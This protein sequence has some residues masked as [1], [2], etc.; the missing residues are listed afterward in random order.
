[1]AHGVGAQDLLP[2]SYLLA[3]FRGDTAGM[4]K[5]L[6]AAAGKPEVE[7]QLLS[8]Q[9]DTE[10]YFGRLARARDFSRRARESAQQADAS[11]AAALWAVC[12]ALHEAEIGDPTK[13][14]EAALAALAREPGLNVQAQ[15]ILALA[16]SGDRIR[17]T[18]LA[19]KL[20]RQH[21][22]DTMLNSYWLPT[23]RAAV[24]LD[25]KK[26]QAALVALEPAKAYE[27]GSPPS[28]VGSLYPI[29][30][31]GL[32]YLEMG[33]GKEAAAEFQ[34]VLDHRGIIANFPTAALARLQL[35]R[36]HAMSGDRAAS[37]KSYEDF[38]ALWKDADPHLTM[39]KQAKLEYGK[40]Q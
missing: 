9:S 21:P 39:L 4:A 40:L 11:E 8:M 16:R 24:A 37:R 20:G 23:I 13:A 12:E 32:A 38:L 18:T 7:N 25:E 36:A 26:P 27:L 3:F 22:S 14:R 6:A 31:R 2:F 29:Y 10:A 5:Q 30:L 34:K 17:A 15:A 19:E 28:I 33:Q 1:M 35:G